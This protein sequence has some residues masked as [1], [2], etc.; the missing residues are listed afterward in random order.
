M[1]T[2]SKEKKSMPTNE[3]PQKETKKTEMKKAKNKKKRDG[4]PDKNVPKVP[5][6]VLEE[7]K[8]DKNQSISWTKEK[9]EN[10]EI[11]SEELICYQYGEHHM[12]VK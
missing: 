5:E 3:N 11:E 12:I 2:N 10:G 8:K 7:W 9:A 6:N 4:K 1:S